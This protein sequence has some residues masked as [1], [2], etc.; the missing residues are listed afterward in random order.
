ML[1]YYYFYS[2]NIYNNQKMQKP[3]INLQ[4][5]YFFIFFPDTCIFLLPFSCILFSTSFH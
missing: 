1:T 3:Y 4:F 2:P 5:Y